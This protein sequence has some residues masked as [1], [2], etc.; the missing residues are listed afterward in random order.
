M[1]KLFSTCPVDHFEN[2]YRFFWIFR[3][4]LNLS[5][6][7]PDLWLKF[8]AALPNVHFTCPR[9][10]FVFFLWMVLMFYLTSDSSEIYF[11]FEKKFRRFCWNCISSVPRIFW[12]FLSKTCWFF[13]LVWFLKQKLLNSRRKYFNSRQ[14]CILSEN[15]SNFGEETFGQNRQKFFSP[16]QRNTL[17]KTLLASWNKFH[18]WA[19]NF[20]ICAGKFPGILSYEQYLFPDGQLE[21]CFRKKFYFFIFSRTSR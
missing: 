1:S 11:S 3:K 16:V 15:F 10:F 6:N 13:S 19:R 8:S 14:K 4:F 7:C 20:R 17:T 5:D 21:E 2:D 12:E 18:P 9:D